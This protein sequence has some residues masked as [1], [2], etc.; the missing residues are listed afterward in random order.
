MA[1]IPTGNGVRVRRSSSGQTRDRRLRSLAC[2]ADTADAPS[3]IRGDLLKIRRI[4]PRTAPMVMA[5]W[6][7]RIL[8]ITLG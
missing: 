5:R 8:V 7:A 4:S 6:D 1:A 2:M 3:T